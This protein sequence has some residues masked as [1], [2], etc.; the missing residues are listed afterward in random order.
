MG[1]VFGVRLDDDLAPR[2]REV[3]QEYST[4][5]DALRD[6]I[7]HGINELEGEQ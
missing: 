1:E 3:E 6:A 2:V 5:S 4:R 7:R